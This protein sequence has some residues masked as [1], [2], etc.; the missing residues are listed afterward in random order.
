MQYKEYRYILDTAKGSSTKIMCPNCKQKKCLK[1]YIDTE[2]GQYIDDE[3]GRCDHEQ[4]CGYHYTPKQYFEDHKWQQNNVAKPVQVKS[5]IPQNVIMTIPDNVVGLRHSRKSTLMEWLQRVI[6]DSE[7]LDRVY[8]LYKIGAT[9]IPNKDSQAVIFWYIDHDNVVRDGK[10][11][12]YRTDGHREPNKVNWASAMFRSCGQWPKNAVTDK[13]LFGEHL[14]TLFPEATVAIVESE[15]SAICCAA[16]KPQYI[17]LA[18]GGCGGLNRD[19]VKVLKGRSVIFFPD[20][21]KLQEWRDKMAGVTDFTYRFC[22]SL[23]QYPD[24]TD[25]VDIILGECPYVP[26]AIDS[27]PK[28]RIEEKSDS[29]V[30]KLDSE[31]DII[32]DQLAQEAFDILCMDNE[33]LVELAQEFD[34]VPVEICPF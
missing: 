22:E 28:E 10:F 32:A 34:L 15:K 9:E 5:V 24:N 18:T 26:V 1:R 20:S 13:C 6:A 16:L 11:M 12:W 7:A 23:E 25:L 4:S 29:T 27:K 14:L 21:G 30:A 31:P 19:K 17:W 8:E 3:C 33:A 2:T